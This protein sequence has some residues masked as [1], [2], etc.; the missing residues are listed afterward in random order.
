MKIR[1]IILSLILISTLS[2]CNEDP[3]T[4]IIR[5][6]Q[7]KK[8]ELPSYFLNI[9]D[10]DTVSTIAADFTILSYFDSLGCTSCK[11]HLSNWNRLFDEINEDLGETTINTVLL[12]NTNKINDIK[13]LIEEEFYSYPIFVD[14]ED[15]INQ[16]NNFPDHDIF[17]T[18]LLDKDNKVLAIGNPLYNSGIKDLY[19]SIIRGKKGFSNN[20]NSAILVEKTIHDFGAINIGET[21]NESFIINNIGIDT[22]RITQ[23]ES[24]C[25]CT[26]GKVSSE[27]IL[28]G[29]SIELTIIFKEDSTLG[30]FYRNID[31]FYDNFS[32]PTTFTI[33]GETINNIK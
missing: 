19:F 32:R 5:E 22:V 10:N 4:R 3:N 11:L 16:A 13:D 28:P 24:S 18:F 8:I 25:N 21:V 6:W 12:I 15:K 23:I 31:V 9:I 1:H 30:Q 17:R 14:P 26:V 2:A 33:S 20:Y 29:E 7:G 27:I